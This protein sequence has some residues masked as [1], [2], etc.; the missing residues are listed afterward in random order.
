[1][2]GFKNDINGKWIEKDPNAFLDYSV[3]W[4]NWLEGAETI[5]TSTWYAPTGITKS[6][7]SEL[8]GVATVWLAGGT[9]GKEYT[10]VNRIT[11]SNG[12]QDERSFRVRIQNR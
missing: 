11:T 5:V 2:N 10:I 8:N 9:V 6:N 1:M 4:A 7:E 12:R 3:N